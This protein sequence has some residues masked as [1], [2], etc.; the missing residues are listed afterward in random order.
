MTKTKVI[1]SVALPTLATAFWWM[2][3]SYNRQDEI[4]AA[5][6]RKITSLKMNGFV[7]IFSGR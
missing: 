4:K 2:T 3:R 6:Q 1:A 5:V 7:G